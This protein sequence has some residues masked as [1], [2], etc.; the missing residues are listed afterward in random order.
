[1]LTLG[2][3]TGALAHGDFRKALHMMEASRADAVELSAL[4]ET[5]FPSLLRSLQELDLSR[6]RYVSLHA[7]SRYES[8]AEVHLAD[9]LERLVPGDM[10]IV[11]HPTPIRNWPVWARF[12][13]RLCVE[14]MDKRNPMGR[15]AEELD[16]IFT[17]LPEATLCLDLGHAR[18]IDPTMTETDL[19][20]R[21]F[22]NRVKQIHISEVDA[23]CT[24]R[25]LTW[26]WSLAFHKVAALIPN[27]PI[28]LET[29]LSPDCPSINGLLDIVEDMWSG[30]SLGALAV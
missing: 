12:G 16:R 15:T 8:L 17:R 26:A 13:S 3:S 19:I 7:P 22:G 21:K 11:V 14:N 2:I 18:Q 10:P 23:S 20:L 4:R 6:Y 27:V 5:E 28:I 9:Q 30:Q 29:P 1:M 24:H 25:P